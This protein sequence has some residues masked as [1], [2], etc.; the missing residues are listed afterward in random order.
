MNLVALMYHRARAGALGNA[1]AML[2]AHF[3]LIAA[4]HACVLPGEPLDPRRLSVCL[5]FDDAYYDFYAVVFPLLRK[6]GLRALLAVPAIVVHEHVDASP[7]ERLCAK[8]DVDCT[9]PRDLGFCTWPELREMA[10]SGHVAV[11]AHGYTHRPLDSAT[12]DFHTEI[13]VA[14]TILASRLDQPVES[15]VFP[16]GRFNPPALQKVTALYRHAFRI[17]GAVNRGWARLLYRVDADRLSSPGAPFTSGRL[18]AGRVRYF[19]NRLR[20]R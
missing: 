7:E 5:T 18:A 12:V 13:I 14:K 17:G 6:H 20:R 11:A 4:R 15:F 8:T 1:P 16:Y 10:D 2:D 19:W 9:H 3:A